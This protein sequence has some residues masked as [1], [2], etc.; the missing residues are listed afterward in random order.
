MIGAVVT[1]AQAVAC[2]RAALADA[3]PALGGVA[4]AACECGI[5]EDS[6]RRRLAGTHGWSA[7]DV[8]HVLAAELALAGRSLLVERLAALC[9]GAATV[10]DARRAQGGV[11]AT[12]PRLLDEARAMA[13]ALVDGQVSGAEA[14]AILAGL[15]ELRVLLDELMADL[16]ELLRRGGAR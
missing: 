8:A 5:S 6:V 15:P 14:R 16:A 2:L 3:V 10:G 7:E 11:A 4:A 1:H 13:G 9:A 12:L